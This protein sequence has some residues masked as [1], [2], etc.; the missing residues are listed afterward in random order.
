MVDDDDA[1]RVTKD[2]LKFKNKNLIRRDKRGVVSIGE[3]SLKMLEANGKENLWATDASGSSIPINITNGSD[4]EINGVSVQGQIDSNRFDIGLNRASIS[5]NSS[6]INQNRRNINDLGFGVA[7]STALSTAMSALPTV[8]TDSPISCGVGTGGY[9]S[10]Y[11]MSLG[12]AIRASK[13]L[14]FNA[15]GSYVFGGGADYGNGS[16]SNIAGR[17]GFVFKLGTIQETPSS[18]LSFQSKVKELEASNQ[19]LK[20][21]N[22][23]LL[24]RLE[25]LEAIASAVFLNKVVASK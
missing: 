10:R 14:S 4:L 20:A 15:G 23:E 11:A 22:Q 25:R 1:L 12:C 8:V 17:A 5:A 7:G 19:E 18:D 9:S 13:R 24:A 16:L 6:A 2:G 3:N 21:S